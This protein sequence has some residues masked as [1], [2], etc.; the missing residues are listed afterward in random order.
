MALFTGHGAMKQRPAAHLGSPTHQ[1]PA[2]SDLHIDGREKRRVSIETGIAEPWVDIADDHAVFTDWQG[3]GE[4][5]NAEE[6]KQL[7]ER[8]AIFRGQMMNS[9]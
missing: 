7:R 8:I 9:N 1:K 3:F 5:A 6:K 2:N 4:M